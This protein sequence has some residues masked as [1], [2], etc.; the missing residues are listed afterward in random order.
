[1]KNILSGIILLIITLSFTTENGKLSGIV[2]YK[3][4]YESSSQADAGGEIYAISIADAKSA[5]YGDLAKVVGRFLENKSNYSLSVFNT[6]DP[7]R[8]KTLQDYFDTAANYTAKYISGFRKLAAVVKTSPNEKG[9][10][11]LNLKPGKYYILYI[12]GN[13]KSDNTAESKGNIDLKVADVKSAGETLM[14]E[15]FRKHE[16]FMILLLT[17]RWLQGC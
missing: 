2:T 11:S 10:Y 8:V 9:M 7:E 16:N 14:D 13:V 6:V 12:S 4:T 15:N 5:K 3:D 1:M 17:G